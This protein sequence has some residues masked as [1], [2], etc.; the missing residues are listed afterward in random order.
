MVV[1][2]AIV[3]VMTGRLTTAA[4]AAAA[5]TAGVAV[6]A[7]APRPV[8]PLWQV[9]RGEWIAA[10]ESR[11][12]RLGLHGHSVLAVPVAWEWGELRYGL[13]YPEAVFGPSHSY[14]STHRTNGPVAG[15]WSI[16]GG[17][18]QKTT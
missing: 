14:A 2:L 8:R 1:L 7:L 6:A 9:A 12:E 15:A 4:A 5:A 16:R 13:P 11:L 18:K 3:A 17:L 10:V